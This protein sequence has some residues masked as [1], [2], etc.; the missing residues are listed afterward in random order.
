MVKEKDEGDIFSHTHIN[1]KSH[2]SKSLMEILM[3]SLCEGV[4]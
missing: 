1:I 3:G 4:T 2:D